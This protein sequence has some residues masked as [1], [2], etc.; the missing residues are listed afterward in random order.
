MKKFIFSLLLVSS[1]FL[2]AQEKQFNKEVLNSSLVDLKG[3]EVIFKDILSKHKGK[4]VVMEIWASWCSD[5]VA[6]MPKLKELQKYHPEVDFVFISMDK[7]FKGFQD[8]VEKHNLFKG[9]N[10]FSKTPW[11]ESAFAKNIA[12]DWIPRYILIDEKGEI[13]LFKAIKPDDKKITEFLNK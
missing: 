13:A 7:S 10:Y 3:N 8:G 6:A 12:L 11:K 5:C 2:F 4:K 1:T 9:D